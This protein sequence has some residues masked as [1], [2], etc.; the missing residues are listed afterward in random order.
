MG[1][2]SSLTAR[3]APE[4]RSTVNPKHPRDPVLA[5][6]FGGG[7]AVSVTPDSAMRVTAVYACISLIAETLAALP[8]HVYRKK[9]DPQT[10]RESREK[11][12]DH[13]LY[14]LLHEMP[15]AGMTSFEWREMILSHT[16]LRGDGFA[17]IITDRGGQIAELP[18]ILP[19]HIQ[20]FRDRRGRLL[21][22]W[23]EDGR[24]PTRILFDE[25]V[26]RIPHKMM[27]GVTSLSPIATHR[28][29]IGNALA[30]GQFL[31]SFYANSAQPKGALMSDQP[32]TDEAAKALRKSWEERHQGPEN[33]GRVAIFD[34]G[35][36]WESIGM[37]MDD[38][39]YIELQKF[40]IGDIARI[41]LVPPHK[42][43]EM[44]AATFG[45]IEHQAIEFVVDTILRW[46]RRVESRYN[47]YL[48]TPSDRAAGL[49]AAF[50]MKGLLRGDATARGNFYR[51]LFYIGAISP[52]EI[53]RAEDM[54][55][56]AGGEGY[57]VQGATVPIAA[58]DAATGAAPGSVDAALQAKVEQIVN[59]ALA[60]AQTTP[61]TPP[62]KKVQP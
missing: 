10:G 50:D 35:L 15:V 9:T 52:N 54:N 13:P 1:F 14:R 42:I 62:S 41:Y 26:L 40:S 44:G 5:Q 21:Y 29:T 17:R 2:L 56:Y 34:G 45:N 30:A 48:L 47:A 11:V 18:P 3:S 53:R 7:D 36:K 20:P 33:A 31:R 32:L 25:E 59:D 19:D 58:I 43:G 61:E 57:Y 49:Y 51:A 24:G 46:V 12:A 22:R 37:T 16:A 55:P 60:G 4:Q 6:M 28:Q 39:Q 8:L 23:W 27:D 38:A